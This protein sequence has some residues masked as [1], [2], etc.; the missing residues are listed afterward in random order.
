MIISMS[1]ESY[2]TA[3]KSL[4]V[5]IAKYIADK[6][7][8]S[9]QGVSVVPM[10]SITPVPVTPFLGIPRFLIILIVYLFLFI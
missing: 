2:S 9:K 10:K 6:N 3:T 8:D 1:I 7:V 4:R 5:A